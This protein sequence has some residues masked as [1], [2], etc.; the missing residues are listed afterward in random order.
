MYFSVIKSTCLRL[1]DSCMG[2]FVAGVDRVL[3][4]SSSCV[5]HR[6]RMNSIR[7][8]IADDVQTARR[9]VLLHFLHSETVCVCVWCGPLLSQPSDWCVL[10]GGTRTPRIPSTSAPVFFMFH[11]LY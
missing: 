5:Q 2:Y 11:V 7:L 10:G 3:S 8:S 4:V 6:S 9:C 1:K